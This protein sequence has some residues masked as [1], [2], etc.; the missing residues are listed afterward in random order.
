MKQISHLTRRLN[1]LENVRDVVVACAVLH[2]MLLAYDSGVVRDEANDL[3]FGLHHSDVLG[4]RIPSREFA[5]SGA[6][7]DVV[8]HPQLD[9]SG[10]GTDSA[11]RDIPFHFHDAPCDIPFYFHDGSSEPTHYTLR[12]ALAR[13]LRCSDV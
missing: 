12:N 7:D 4:M 13:H 6:T 2:N 10:S 5:A 3:E 11:P 8:V 1:E 9:V